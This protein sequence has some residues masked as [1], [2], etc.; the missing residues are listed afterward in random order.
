MQLLT[1]PPF[2]WFQ[3][4][5]KAENDSTWTDVLKKLK[6]MAPYVWPKGSLWRQALVLLSLVLLGILRGINVL[7][8]LYNKYIG[9]CIPNSKG[10]ILRQT[11]VL[12]SLV[13]LG[14]LSGIN[15]LVPLYN[16]YIGKCIPY[17][18]GSIWRQAI[19]LLSLESLRVPEGNK[20]PG[21]SL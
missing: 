16:K 7:V 8:P 17:S 3:K 2:L 5:T 6:M 12:L 10:S 15:V 18:K 13:L 20:C 1:R 11:S 14:V 21:T 19:V 4:E 9:K